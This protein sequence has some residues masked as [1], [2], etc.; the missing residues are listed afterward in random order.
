M[1]A[2]CAQKNITSR[3]RGGYVKVTAASQTGTFPSR[4]CSGTINV[5]TKNGWQE[6][7]FS[8]NVFYNFKNIKETKVKSLKSFDAYN[9]LYA[10]WN[11][12]K[13]NSLSTYEALKNS[14]P[15]AMIEADRKYAQGELALSYINFDETLINTLLTELKEFFIA[16]CNLTFDENYES[17]QWNYNDWFLEKVNDEIESITN[18]L[19]LPPWI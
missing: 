19:G 16:Y 12:L 10:I 14:Y 3:L 11:F 8:R 18:P 15:E 7:N 13:H 17:A 6:K 9:K 5:L 4:R 2:V 1:Y